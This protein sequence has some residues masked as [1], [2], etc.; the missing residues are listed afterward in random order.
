MF[1]KQVSTGIIF[2]Y[3]FIY[4]SSEIIVANSRRKNFEKTTKWSNKGGEIK[5]QE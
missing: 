1:V 4:S 5:S 3:L 2:I